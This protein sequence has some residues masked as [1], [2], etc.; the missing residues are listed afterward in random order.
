[1]NHDDFSKPSKKFDRFDFEQQIMTCWCITTD[2]KDL[3][4]SVMERGLN[5]DRVANILC[6]IEQLYELRFQK[7]FEQFEDMVRG[8]R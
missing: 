7:L 5:H 2:L 1:M 3:R 8:Q 6:G 4:E